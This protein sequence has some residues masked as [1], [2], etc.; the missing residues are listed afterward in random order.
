MK[1]WQHSKVF[2]P[3]D[4]L[5]AEGIKSFSDFMPSAAKLSLESEVRN[6]ILKVVIFWYH[7]PRIYKEG[8]TERAIILCKLNKSL[9][10]SSIS[11]GIIR[12]KSLYSL[13]NLCI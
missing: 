4:N 8:W 6:F 12:Q 2:Y 5:A 3:R 11:V 7:V 9:L 1:K 10:E 13:K